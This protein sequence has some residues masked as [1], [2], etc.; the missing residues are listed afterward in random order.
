MGE[1]TGLLIGAI[2]WP[3]WTECARWR[4]L[5]QKGVESEAL[6]QNFEDGVNREQAIWYHHEVA[7]MMLL[8]GLMC[9][10]NG[11]EF[12]VA[13]WKRLGFE[14]DAYDYRTFRKSY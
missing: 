7:D 2:T 14:E 6:K 3:L 9:R 10:A 1:Y 8:C 13:F 5:A 12:H 4:Q 11:V